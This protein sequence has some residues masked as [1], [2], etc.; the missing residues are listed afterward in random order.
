[1]PLGILHYVSVRG[2]ERRTAFLGDAD[3]AAFLAR[4]AALAERGP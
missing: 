4:L 1:M 3:R 2:L